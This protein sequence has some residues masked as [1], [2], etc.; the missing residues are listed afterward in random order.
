ML[1]KTKLPTEHGILRETWTATTEAELQTEYKKV[2]YCYPQMGY[3][4]SLYNVQLDPALNM[5]TGNF[6]RSLSCD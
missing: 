3:G 5:W 6:R 1:T 2:E 4:T